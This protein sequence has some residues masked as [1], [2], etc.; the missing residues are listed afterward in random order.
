MCRCMLLW[1]LFVFSC[2]PMMWLFL[3][4][5]AICLFGEG[6]VQVFWSFLNWIVCFSVDFWEF[7]VC[8][9]YIAFVR[10]MAS[11]YFSPAGSLSLSLT[12]QTVFHK[13][14][15]AV[16]VLSITI[17]LSIA[18]KGRLVKSHMS[19]PTQVCHGS[20]PMALTPERSLMNMFQDI[21]KM[22]PKA[23]KNLYCWQSNFR[24]SPCWP[25][26]WVHGILPFLE[27]SQMPLL[28]C[29]ARSTIYN[30]RKLSGHFTPAHSNW[31]TYISNP[32]SCVAHTG[33]DSEQP[34]MWLV[35]CC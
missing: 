30:V 10:Y 22:L 23:K 25:R 29:R 15:L 28:Q 26:Q 12:F 18:P 8:F 1:L 33:F 31:Q 6:S 9:R 27:H 32:G 5:L 19:E 7:F 35:Q 34:Q 14:S 21:T 16:S 11:K 3:C 4:L 20:L 13:P 2:W 24:A 17:P